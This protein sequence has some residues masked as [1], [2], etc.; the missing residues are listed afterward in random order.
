MTT[1]VVPDSIR[2]ALEPD[3]A[4]VERPLEERSAWH[5]ALV[6]VHHVDVATPDGEVA[7]REIVRH[8]GGCGVLV[9]RDGLM[10]LVRQWRTALGRMTLELPAGKLEPGEDPLHC[11]ARELREETGLVATDLVHVASTT[12]I[13]GFSDELTRVFWARSWEEGESSTDADEFVGVVWLPVE[14]VLAAVRA[15]AITDAKT[16]VATLAWEAGL[17]G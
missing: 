15:G 11:A 8:P 4:L 9:V 7:L 1:L 14:D 17:C 16:V 6:D 2:R 3:P 5:G 10:C 13:I 12:G